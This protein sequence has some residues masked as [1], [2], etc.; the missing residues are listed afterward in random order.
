[1]STNL[2]GPMILPRGGK[3]TSMVI[4]LHGYGSNGDDLIGIGE[5]WAEA[6]PNTVFL[7]PNAPEVCEQWAAGYQWFGIRA[8]DRASLERDKPAARV[9]PILNNYIKNS[10]QEFGI[11]DKKLFVVG[12]SQGAMM[13]MYAMP[14]R[15]QPCGGVIGYSGMLLEPEGLK[16]AGISKMPILAIHGRD[17][18]VVPAHCLGEVEAGFKAAHFDV[19]TFLRPGLGHGIDGFGLAQGLEFIMRN[20]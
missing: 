16:A 8:I 1:M 20:Q 11:E 14:R 10:I 15:P 7:S 9:A 12:F 2:S 3:A 18:Q 5:E 13:A 4:F 19:Q 6:L 17:D